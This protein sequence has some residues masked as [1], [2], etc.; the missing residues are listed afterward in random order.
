MPNQISAGASDQP[1]STYRAFLLRLWIV[2]DAGT[3]AWRASIEDARTGTR[4]GFANLRSLYE[5]LEIQMG[6]LATDAHSE[7][8]DYK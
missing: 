7:P 2:N 5:F 8:E 1:P 6:D 4:R 3:V